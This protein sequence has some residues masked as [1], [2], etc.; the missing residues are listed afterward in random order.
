Q[1]I[2]VRLA[3]GDTVVVAGEMSHP[4]WSPTGKS[5]AWIAPTAEHTAGIVVTDAAGKNP[6]SLTQGARSILTFA[7]AS[8]GTWIAAVEARKKAASAGMRLHWMGTSSDSLDTAPPKRELWRVDVTSGKE[9]PLVDDAWSYGGR[10][11][12]RDPCVS[13]DGRKVLATRQPT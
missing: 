12:D 5:I 13:P 2:L 10:A 7:W 6:R 8:D 1:Y 4:R 11:G 3:D 9:A